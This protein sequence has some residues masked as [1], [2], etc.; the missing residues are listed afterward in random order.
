MLL[1]RERTKGTKRGEIRSDDGMLFID[2]R[3][4][5]GVSSLG[6]AECVKC[7]SNAV[8]DHGIPVR[9]LMRKENDTEYSEN[10]ISVV[11]EIS[12][13]CSLMRT[14]SSEKIPARCK[15]CSCSISKNAKEIWDSFPEPRFET[16]RSEAERS[17]P[18]KDGCEECM[19]KTLG[20]IDRAEIMFS[21]LGKRCAK[22][23]FRLTEV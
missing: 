13:I 21:D 11:G 9:L 10:V 1:F 16:M 22:D 8:V 5:K 23:A 20:F 15:G 17:N 7:V 2:C 18:G 4:C 14:I 3:P 12:K 19:W 6:D